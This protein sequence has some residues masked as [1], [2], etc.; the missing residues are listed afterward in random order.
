MPAGSGLSFPVGRFSHFCLWCQVRGQCRAGT[1]G[2]RGR[3]GLVGRTREDVG[4]EQR[5]ALGPSRACSAAWRLASRC[6]AA[7]S[8]SSTTAP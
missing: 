7:A 3:R 1:L 6:P 5:G 8:A 2:R 4:A